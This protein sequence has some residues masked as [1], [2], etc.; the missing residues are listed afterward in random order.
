MVGPEG[1]EPSPDTLR[2]CGATVTP[3]TH[4]PFFT[5][6]IACAMAGVVELGG[7]EPPSNLCLLVLLRAYLGY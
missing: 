2:A 4:M 7:V 1:V 6:L 5:F 3:E